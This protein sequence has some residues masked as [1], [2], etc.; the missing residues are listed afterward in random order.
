MIRIGRHRGKPLAIV[1][2]P[3]AQRSGVRA[4]AALYFFPPPRPLIWFGEHLLQLLDAFEPGGEQ[5]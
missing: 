2:T 1:I 5:F 4:R 3:L